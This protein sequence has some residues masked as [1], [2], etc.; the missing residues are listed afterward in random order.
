MLPGEPAEPDGREGACRFSAI[1]AQAFTMMRRKA[2][3]Q[4]VRMPGED[5]IASVTDRRHCGR[6]SDPVTIHLAIDPVACSATMRSTTAVVAEH[7]SL[8]V[9]LA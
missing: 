4:A 1:D 5:C 7:N 2:E 9:K 8:W 3:S 6:A